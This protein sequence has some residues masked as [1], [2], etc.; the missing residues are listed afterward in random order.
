MVERGASEYIR[1]RDEDGHQERWVTPGTCEQMS[2]NK[3]VMFRNSKEGSVTRAS[4][5]G[6]VC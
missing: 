1:W 5:Q 2:G 3:L 6:G 4:G